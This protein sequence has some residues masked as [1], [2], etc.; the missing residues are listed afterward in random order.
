M[1]FLQ[2]NIALMGITIVLVSL[3][4]GCLI[5]SIHALKDKLAKI[6]QESKIIKIV[7]E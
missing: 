5:Y 4:G 7:K 2:L 6:E 1:T 3:M